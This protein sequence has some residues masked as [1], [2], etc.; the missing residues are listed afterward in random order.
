MKQFYVYA[1]LK[2]DVVDVHSIFYIGKGSGKRA[3]F[4]R[5]NNRHHNFVINKYGI[6]NIIV[7]KIL[8]DSEEHAL[9]LETEMISIL[10]RMGVN[11]TNVTEGGTG[12]TGY[13]HSEEA[14]K[15]ISIAHKDKKLSAEHVEKCRLAHVG[16]KRTPEQNEA[17]RLRQLGKIAS[18]ET[19]DKISL[20]LKGNTR[21]LEYK[22]SVEAREKA[23]LTHTGN[24][25][26]L[27]KKN[28]LGY[29]QSDEAKF[30]IGLAHKG[31]THCLGKTWTQTDEQ[32]AKNSEKT[33][34]KLWF[35]NGLV[36]VMKYECPEG[37][38]PGRLKFTRA[39]K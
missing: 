10:R 29:K 26:N 4:I 30:K 9:K 13:S 39:T 18:K 37:F 19:R 17:N 3:C 36:S 32:K 28:A 12:T 15:K 25:Y 1:H 33:K 22:Q 11:L 31:N 23:I 27:G 5:R 8:C 14:K 34:G 21:G 2:P 7:R 35:N 16:L 24:K 38:V 6:E 20:S